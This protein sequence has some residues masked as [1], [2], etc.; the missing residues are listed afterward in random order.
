MV[1]GLGFFQ[2]HRKLRREVMKQL[3]IEKIAS[4]VTLTRKDKLLRWAKL[5]RERAFPV[6]IYNELEH[7]SPAMM[8]MELHQLPHASAFALAAKDPVFAAMGLG[9]HP[10]LND[11]MKFFELTL[12]QVHAFSCDCGGHL[13]NEQQAR[14]IECLAN[15][16]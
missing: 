10:S 13:T 15:I 6:G 12:D 1:A 4:T 14:R 8:A 2:C 3:D 11:A 16:R 5:I 7:W 9:K